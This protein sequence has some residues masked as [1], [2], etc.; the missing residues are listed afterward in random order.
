[1]SSC[2]SGVIETNIGLKSGHLP[3]VKQNNFHT[4]SV[5]FRIYKC[6]D[7]LNELSGILGKSLSSKSLLE[8]SILLSRLYGYTCRSKHDMA[9]KMSFKKFNMAAVL[10]KCTP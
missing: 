8:R 7:V 1:M 10:G 2:H 3:T 4:G 9:L 6:G 5:F